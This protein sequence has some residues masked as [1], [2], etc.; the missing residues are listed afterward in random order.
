VDALVT[1]LR[2]TAAAAP[3]I[4]WPPPAVV[5]DIT[6][7]EREIPAP[8]TPRR[9]SRRRV[10]IAAALGVA[11]VGGGGIAA[12]I[13]NSQDD[14][15]AAPAPAAATTSPAAVVAGPRTGLLRW[16]TKLG[17]FISSGPAV[18]PDLVYAGAQQTVRALD[19]GTGEQ[20]WSASGE[21]EF[22]AVIARTDDALYIGD[23]DGFVYALDPA[24]GDRRWRRQVG[25]YAD[26]DPIVAGGTVYAVG[27][28]LSSSK[29]TGDVVA[30]DA[31]TG[32]RRWNHTIT[33]RRKTVHV[34]GDTV[35]V[36]ATDALLALDAG[37][38]AERWRRPLTEP[39]PAVS[40][41]GTVYCGDK[42]GTLHALDLGTGDVQWT[43]SASPDALVLTPWLDPADGRIY[44]CDGAGTLVMVDPVQRATGWQF[45]AGASNPPVVR[46][47]RAV[48]SGNRAVHAVDTATGRPQWR[49]DTP[50][51]LDDSVRPAVTDDSVYFGDTDGGFFALDVAGGTD[52]APG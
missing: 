7:V 8:P 42:A 52:P 48:V 45:A 11:T 49:F 17:D 2:P 44:L 24:T 18:G 5:D 35:L 14:P 46:A 16:Q 23:A 20:R 36:A 26:T 15:V 51:Y 27:F 13:V 1:R 30:L 33:T 19:L 4:A 47:G 28:P 34:T 40:A 29:H 9:T 6:R 38:G 39:S 50:G 22:R 37:S 32:A 41:A 43:T 3:T 12:L 10:L 21:G 25:E 31:R